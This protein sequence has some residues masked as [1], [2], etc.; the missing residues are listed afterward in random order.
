MLRNFLLSKGKEKF[1][2]LKFIEHDFIFY[3]F[4]AILFTVLQ[5]NTSNQLFTQTHARSFTTDTHTNI[6]ISRILA[7]EK[8]YKFHWY[9]IF[10][11]LQTFVLLYVA[12]KKWKL[13]NSEFQT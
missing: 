11:L 7:T 8:Q 4:F 10:I 9:Y 13:K 3:C 12:I 2:N 1:T 6:H 5:K